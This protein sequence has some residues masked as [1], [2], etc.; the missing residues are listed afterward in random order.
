MA[1]AATHN[2]W[3][4]ERY[5]AV[6]HGIKADEKADA[7]AIASLSSAAGVKD[8]QSQLAATI[9]QNFA[10]M[11][12]ATLKMLFDQDMEHCNG[13]SGRAKLLARGKQ[14]AA[15]VTPNPEQFKKQSILLKSIDRGG[16]DTMEGMQAASAGMAQSQADQKVREQ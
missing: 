8:M 5:R 12:P 7:T 10:Q 15:L 2:A 1:F 11:P 13:D 4:Q 3:I 9:A 6:D 16:P 14:F